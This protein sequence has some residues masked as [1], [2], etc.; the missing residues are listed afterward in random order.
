MSLAGQL[1]KDLQSVR[2][3]ASLDW[4]EL[5]AA[6]FERVAVQAEPVCDIALRDAQFVLQSNGIKWRTVESAAF[7]FEGGHPALSLVYIH[8]KLGSLGNFLDVDLFELKTMAVQ[9]LLG[10]P[11]VRTPRR[12]I[13][14][15]DVIH[16]PLIAI[17]AESG[18]GM[19]PLQHCG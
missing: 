12:G 8:Y 7:H 9:E 15:Y 1:F 13:H 18:T 2:G 17:R 4:P 5:P 14:S 11:A 16:D 6:C 3:N 10:P 19:R